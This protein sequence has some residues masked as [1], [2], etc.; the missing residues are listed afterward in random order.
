MPIRIAPSILAADFLHLDKEI[1]M[2]NTYADIIHLDVM[3]GS[4][5]PNISF[6]FSV[7]EPVS[8]IARIPMDA[9]LMIVHPEKYIKRIAALGIQMISVHLE[10]ILQQGDDPSEMLNSI[11]SLGCQAGLAFNP[12]VPVEE[13]Y[14]Y[15]K[16]CDYVLAMSVRAGFGGQNI[17]PNIYSRV[18]T[19]KAEIERQGLTTPVEIDGGVTILNAPELAEAGVDI[20]VAGSTVFKATDPASV[21][22]FL[23]GAGQVPLQEYNS[24]L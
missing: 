7:L 1:E 16:D 8:K 20:F 3:D 19:L 5:V 9:H 24:A 13:C 6:G 23:R 15:L 22:A 21:I 11:R 18:K 12:D 14:P 17:D 4:F 10:A 2:L